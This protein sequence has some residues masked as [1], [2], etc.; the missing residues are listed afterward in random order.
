VEL[1]ATF[2]VA[3]FFVSRKPKKTGTSRPRFTASSFV[4]PCVG[5]LTGEPGAHYT[6]R[7]S[8]RQT[9]EIKG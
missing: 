7:L 6:S 9:P 5:A 3:L 2:P 4:V 8:A 1:S